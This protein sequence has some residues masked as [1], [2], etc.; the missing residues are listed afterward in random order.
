[1]AEG[2][3]PFRV[4]ILHG[5][6][7]GPDTNWFPWLHAALEAEGVDVVRPR[8]PTPGGQSLAAWLDAFDRTVKPLASAP[9]A[10]VG[11]SLG[12]AFALRL[13]ERSVEPLA[14]LFLAAGFVGAL[15][16]PDYDPINRSFFAAPFD[17]VAIRARKGRAARCWA[18]SDDPYVP[19]FRSQEMATR[20]DAPLEI[21]PGGGH[22][23]GEA[24]FTAFPGMRDAILSLRSGWGTVPA[25]PS[26]PLAAP[27][28]I[29]PVAT[30][31]DLADVAGLFRAYA[32]SLGVD[33]GY[34]GFE[35]EVAGLP[36]RY[37][38][39]PGALLLARGP[40]GEVLGCAA[41]RPMAADGCC[42]MKRLYV[43][44]AGRGMGLGRALVKA[45]L[46]EGARIGYREMR[47]DTLPF[48]AAAIALYHSAGFVPVP[49][50]YDT[51]VAGTVFLG[52][53]LAEVSAR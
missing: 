22:L 16:L 5:A 45:V 4:V 50:Y 17:W 32:A 28:R 1:M 10:L 11:H 21:V 25:V 14:G 15:G 33:L 36:G 26:P 2:E 38:P 48:M 37:A 18:G 35:E 8:F 19:L 49:A 13:V 47:L 51:P 24:G 6:R 9:T 30:G 12:A 29:A 7:G 42:E 31:A 3:V 27:F 52:R 39:P 41:L 44:P 43:S 34:Q 40:A 53:S 20:L 23:S 46:L